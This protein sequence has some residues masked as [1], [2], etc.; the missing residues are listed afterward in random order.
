M[1][2]AAEFRGRYKRNVKDTLMRYSMQCLQGSM[3]NSLMRAEERWKSTCSQV[4]R[5]NNMKAGR[6]NTGGSQD[7]G[8]K[9][10]TISKW[11]EMRT[12]LANTRLAGIVT[13]RTKE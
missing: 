5:Q 13:Q 12:V 7:E 1:S 8:K 10:G 9:D 6:Q 2:L 4:G 11:T 3:M